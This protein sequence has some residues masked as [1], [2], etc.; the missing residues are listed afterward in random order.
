MVHNPEKLELATYYRKRGFSYSEIA[1]LCGVSKGTV[2]NWLANQKFSKQVKAD[3]TLKAAKANRNR[4]ALVQK[5][6]QAE[7]DKRYK[8]AETAAITEFRHYKRD[9]AFLAALMVYQAAGDLKQSSQIRLTSN[10]PQL[11]RIF[12]RF[13]CNYLG[14]E[15]KQLRFWLLLY[16][17][18]SET[19]EQR[20][21]SQKIKLSPTQFGKTQFH[22]GH[23]EILH[24]ATG[25]TIIGSTVLKR[26]LQR[27]LQLA[28]K[29]L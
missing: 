12:I 16:E 29:E 3:N 6:Q 23:T 7:R 27:W 14:V 26:K 21:W 9:P 20:W 2:S 28:L 13:A 24:N 8:E 18:Q 10:D 25:S 17:N 4:I 11:H 22:S 1:K 5:A 15:R 19:I